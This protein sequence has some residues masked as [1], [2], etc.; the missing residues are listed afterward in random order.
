LLR[1]VLKE[2]TAEHALLGR[3]GELQVLRDAVVG[4]YSGSLKLATDPSPSNLVLFEKCQVL[5][6]LQEEDV[7]LV[8]LRLSRDDVHEGRLP[9]AIGADDAAKFSFIQDEG[10]IG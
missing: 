2:Q 1:G 6:V 7:A 8:R 5:W 4:K 10:Q 9:G 3:E